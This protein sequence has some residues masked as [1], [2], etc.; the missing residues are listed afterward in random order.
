MLRN[1][2]PQAL[3]SSALHDDIFP[4]HMGTGDGIGS[5]MERELD[6]EFS[7]RLLFCDVLR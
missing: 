7:T 2:P 3:P 5:P 6:L 4:L 1:G